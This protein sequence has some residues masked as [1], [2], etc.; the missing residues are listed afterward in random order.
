MKKAKTIKSDPI[1]IEFYKQRYEVYR[2]L[3]N[4]IANISHIIEK[5][6]ENH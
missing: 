2:S 1:A 3:H 4:E 6:E 5:H